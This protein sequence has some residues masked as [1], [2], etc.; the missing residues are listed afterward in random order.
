MFRLI[1]K[2]SAVSD[3]TAEEECYDVSA[4]CP[5][6]GVGRVQ[7]ADLILDLRKLPKKAG[8]ARSLADEVVV[9]QQAAEIL[10]DHKLTGF[11]LRPVSHRP[12]KFYGP[13][14]F[15]IVQTGRELIKHAADLGIRHPSREFSVWFNGKENSRELFRRVLAESA[16]NAEKRAS[17]RPLPIWYQLVPSGLPVSL[18]SAT[19]FGETPL[20]HDEEGKY[21][22]SLGHTQGWT[23]LS[24]AFVIRSTWDGS[25][26][27][28][29]SQL[30]GKH[31]GPSI[32][33]PCPLFLISRRMK[34][35]L[36]QNEIGSQSRDCSPVGRLTRNRPVA[37]SVLNV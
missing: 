36:A 10:M 26:F 35:V 9:S 30:V 22:C 8:F 1:W 27:C 20:D 31:E 17:N 15:A 16:V 34:S 23:L 32:F 24:E 18:A 13:L 3:Q 4:V 19:K 33:Y 29:T 37:A 2:P 6:C 7:R 28:F 11:T 14:S 21:R 5:E 25:D 12:S